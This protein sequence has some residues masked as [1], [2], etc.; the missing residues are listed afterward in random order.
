MTNWIYTSGRLE[1]RNQAGVLLL[2][3]QA[4]PMWAPLAD[5][6]N[7]NQRL[8]RLLLAGH[9]FGDNPA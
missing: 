2:V 3:I 7:A 8:S 1:A 5:L 6:F 9:G 4:A